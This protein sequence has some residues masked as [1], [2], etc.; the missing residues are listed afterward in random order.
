[1]PLESVL[2]SHHS[3][4]YNP[5]KS[6]NIWTPIF[7]AVGAQ[8]WQRICCASAFGSSCFPLATPAKIVLGSSSLFGFGRL[9]DRCGQSASDIPQPKQTKTRDVQTLPTNDSKTRPKKTNRKQGKHANSCSGRGIA[10]LGLGWSIHIHIGKL[11]GKYFDCLCQSCGHD[12][13]QS[14]CHFNIGSLLRWDGVSGRP[15]TA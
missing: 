14:L 12:C 3:A 13:F 6:G 4:I 1:M 9:Q 5:E 8:D 11:H 15:L 7:S 10:W 2:W